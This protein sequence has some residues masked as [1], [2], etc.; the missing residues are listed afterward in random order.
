[1]RLPS[2]V[3]PFNASILAKF[4]LL[5]NE[6]SAGDIGVMALFNKVKSEIGG[7]A[8]YLETLECLFALRKIELNGL[9]E[10]LHYVDGN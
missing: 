8:D 6:I 10:E 1:M 4:P 2:K 9:S 3:T 5:L 7:T